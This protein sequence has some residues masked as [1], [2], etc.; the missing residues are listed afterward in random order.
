[1]SISLKVL[2]PNQNVY[3]GG[4]WSAITPLSARSIERDGAP[5][6]FPDFTRGDWKKTKTLKIVS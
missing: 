5:E 4:F 6:S 3:E 1:M 2:A